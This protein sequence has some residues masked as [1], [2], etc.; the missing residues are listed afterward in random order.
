MHAEDGDAVGY[1]YKIADS[2]ERVIEKQCAANVP[3]HNVSVTLPWAATVS[4]YLAGFLLPCL[5]LL[6]AT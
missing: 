5:R 3:V 2:F 1:A 6:L 4:Q